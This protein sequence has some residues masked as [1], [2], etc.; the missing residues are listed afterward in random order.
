MFGQVFRSNDDDDPRT[1]WFIDNVIGFSVVVGHGLTDLSSTSTCTKNT[2]LPAPFPRNRSNIIRYSLQSL[3]SRIKSPR[4][5]R[6][7]ILI[8]T[9]CFSISRT[10]SN[11]TSSQFRYLSIVFSLQFIRETVR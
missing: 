11:S 3:T 2:L 9:S 4:P 5:I 7:W 10:R 8:C 6:I 1:C